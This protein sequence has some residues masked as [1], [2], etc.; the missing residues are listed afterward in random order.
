MNFQGR[1]E[2]YAWNTYGAIYVISL[3]LTPLIETDSVS[4]QIK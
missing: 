1:R 2:N 3:G 4:T